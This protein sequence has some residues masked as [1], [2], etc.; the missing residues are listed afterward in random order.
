MVVWLSAVVGV[1]VGWRRLSELGFLGL[2]DFWDC[3]LVF[4]GVG[5]R[6]RERGIYVDER[7]E[8]DFCGGCGLVCACPVV[9]HPRERAATRVASTSRSFALRKGRVVVKLLSTPAA[10][11]TQ[12]YRMS[13]AL[14]TVKSFKDGK[15][16]RS[17]AVEGRFQKRDLSMIVAL[18]PIELRCTDRIDIPAILGA[19]GRFSGDGSECRKPQRRRFSQITKNRGDRNRIHLGDLLVSPVLGD[20]ARRRRMGRCLFPLGSQAVKLGVHFFW[21]RGIVILDFEGMR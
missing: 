3:G 14:V 21:N 20:H 10:H 18:A 7:D 6:R 2:R 11:A 5:L 17:W 19:Y 4:G 8:R 12:L 13:C 1:L 16:S 15:S 9:G